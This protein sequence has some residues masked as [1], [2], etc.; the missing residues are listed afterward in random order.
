M[1]N[2]FVLRGV[3]DPAKAHLR[4]DLR[5]AHLAYRAQL[6]D[7]LGGPLLDDDGRPVGSLV[8]FEADDGEDARSITEHDPYVA[9]G[10]FSEWTLDRFH[11][12]VWVS[13]DA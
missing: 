3:V 6:R 4:D 11:P 13:P 8:V 12:A 7:L 2:V 5:P 9:N 10:L 1:R